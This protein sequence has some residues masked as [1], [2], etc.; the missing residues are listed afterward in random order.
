MARE[1]PKA[2]P[3]KLRATLGT[4]VRRN[5]WREAGAWS[6]SM[7]GRKPKTNAERSV[8]L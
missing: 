7:T 2:A 5:W 8:A 4:L 1:A 3:G 6:P